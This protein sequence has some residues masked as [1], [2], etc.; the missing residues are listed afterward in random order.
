MPDDDVPLPTSE[1]LEAPG[2]LVKSVNFE[3]GYPDGT[4]VL[5]ISTSGNRNPVV[6]EGPDGLQL[7]NV[8]FDGAGIGLWVHRVTATGFIGRWSEWG[9]VRD[10][11]GVFC[12][13]LVQ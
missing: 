9:I 4:P 5:L 7:L 1:D 10:G 2:V 12:A 11:R 3:E 6:G 8:S 13:E